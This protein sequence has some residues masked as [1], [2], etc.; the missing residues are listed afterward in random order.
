MQLAEHMFNKSMNSKDIFDHD[1][2]ESLSD[3][4]Y[5]MGKEL[6]AKKQYTLAVKWLQRAYEVLNSD[7]LDKLSANATELRTSIIQ[8]LVKALLETKSNE[9]LQRAQDLVDLLESEIGDKMVVLLLRMELLAEKGNDVFDGLAYSGILQRLV[10]T[11]SL[12]TT[13][14][15]LFLF[16]ARKLS[17]KAPS[18]AVKVLDE[19]V[20]LR[21][22]EWAEIAALGEWLEK[23]LVTRIWMVVS[24]RDIEEGFVGTEAF[25]DLIADNVV[26]G[27]STEATMAVHTVSGDDAVVFS[28]SSYCI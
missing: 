5:E 23:V 28:T 7:D 26:K 27:M 3:A 20:R 18:L 10:R 13:N 15:R 17:D 14:L 11:M 22:K 6:L 16:H 8:T 21:I 24:G 25:L 19:L 1:T 4:L 12:S 9:S 2:T